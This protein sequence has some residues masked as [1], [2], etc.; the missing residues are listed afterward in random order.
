MFPIHWTLLG[1]Q[2]PFT[3][4]DSWSICMLSG[5][6]ESMHGHVFIYIPSSW[7]KISFN[8]SVWLITL[9]DLVQ[10]KYKLFMPIAT[11]PRS[12]KAGGRAA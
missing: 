4:L 6:H 10:L 2:F 7:A 8:Q 9:S 5:L 11:H 12:I 3:G 1:G